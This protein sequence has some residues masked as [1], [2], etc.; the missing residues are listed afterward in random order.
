[1]TS[2]FDP[3]TLEVLWT[4]IISVVD[5]AAKAIVRTSFSTLS[6][7]ANDFA[8]VLTDARGF[9][10]AQNSGSIPSFIGTL[11]ATVRH[12][13]REF[14]AEGL[15][16]GDVLITNDPWQGTGHMSDV[17]LVKPIF[18]HGRLA[19]FSATTS[20]MPDIGGRV[21][22]IEAREL[23]EEGIHIP[24]SRI[25]REGQRDE[26]LIRLI[27]ANVRTPDQTMGD[28]WAQVSANELM[29]SRVR[30]LMEEYGLDS[31]EGLADELF[32]RS[33]RAMRDA[34]R[35][36]PDGT[37]RYGFETDGFEKPYTF[38]IALTV[39]GDEIT[40][41]FTGTSP[42][43]PRAINCVYA[44]TYAMT[45]Y[46][47]RC[48]LLSRLPNNEGMYRPVKVEVPEGCLL[49][50]KFPAAVV[51]RAQTG[52]Y[53]PLLVLGALHQVIPDK[54]MAGAG[55]PLWAVAQSGTRDDGRPYTNVLFFNGGMGAT[56][57]KDGEHVLS[58][59][60][61][62]SST[63]VEVAE[64]N[65]PLFF[66]HKRLRPGSGGDGRHR[67]GLGQDMLIESGSKRP[68]VLSF[69]AE[70]TKF[71]APGFAGGAAGG[72]GDVRING[73]KVDH[74][75]QHVLERGDRV[76]VSTP[77]GGGYG[78]AG[79]RP[80]DLRA[81][82]QERGYVGRG[83]GPLTLPSPRR[84]EG[85]RVTSARRKGSPGTRRRKDR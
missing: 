72:L 46:A 15:R 35:T 49:N 5:E 67:G 1:M 62:I 59:P 73:K 20:H 83:P 57:A 28:I 61:N 29:E 8:C 22:A 27:R 47:V 7:E 33:E 19:A 21:R 2:G 81:R 75:R 80:A 45:A 48:A 78:P 3:I 6:N 42:A 25:I 58:W 65:S 60:S 13:L 23:F 37:Y 9:A 11:P 74:R 38:R 34:I 36:V 66:H 50:P 69:M 52:H 32:G 17:C 10:L 53:V 55:S 43:Q 16:P 82:D 70:R 68:I 56:S 85:G 31:L 30:R 41:D 51:S 18:Q 26:T 84:G 40:A 77:G 12:F 63:P 54:V 79:Q 39:R 24:L 71:S 4:R 76:L 64:R 44:Y 14:G